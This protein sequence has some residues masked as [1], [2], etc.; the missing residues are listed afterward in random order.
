MKTIVCLFV[1]LAFAAAPMWAQGEEKPKIDPATYLE[2]VDTAPTIVGG[3]E[4]LAKNI[5]YPEDAARDGVQGM[6]IVRVLVAAS[7]RIDKASIEKSDSPLLSEAAL[8]AVRAVRFTPGKNDDQPV[9]CQVMVPV[10][11]RL[12]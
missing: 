3:M 5:V 10:K 9:K 12:K 7:G 2:E 11:F 8:E 4:A 1:L 6:V